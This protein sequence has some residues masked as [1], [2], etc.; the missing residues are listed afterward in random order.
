MKNI[1]I[2]T[3]P[4]AFL[5]DSSGRF[6]SSI[7]KVGGT[8]AE[9]RRI[10]ET[11]SVQEDNVAVEF[12][13]PPAKSRQEFVNYVTSGI[14]KLTEITNPYRLSFIPKA[15]FDE[16]QLT[17]PKAKEIGCDPDYSVYGGGC[18]LTEYPGN[19][20]FAAG[21]IH[22]GYDKPDIVVSENLVPLLDLFVGIPSIIEEEK[23][24]RREFYGK[25]GSIRIKPYGLEYRTLSNYWLKDQESV[26][27]VYDRTLHAIKMFNNDFE[28]DAEDYP[29]M[30]EAINTNNKELAQQLVNKYEL[31]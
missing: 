14:Q 19:E 26:G 27:L 5:Q 22:I 20:R 15:I 7:G 16:E 28:L 29:T 18:E 31:H 13:T 8:K 6:I 11:L 12:N 21:H 10:D 23:T 2:G 24:N 9:P 17:D 3:D 30:I 25:A 4:E 1:T